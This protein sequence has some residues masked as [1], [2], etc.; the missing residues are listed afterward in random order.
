M[1][2]IAQKNILLTGGSG[3]IGR[4]ILESFLSDKYH[5]LAPSS[6][7]LNLPDEKSVDAYFESHQIDIVVHSAVKPGHRNAKDFSDLFYT[8]TRM[9]LTWSVTRK[10]MKNVGDRL[11]GYIR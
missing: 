7:E 4:N 6:R 2:Q 9:F 3:F 1:E 8:N 11:W 5:I 10:N